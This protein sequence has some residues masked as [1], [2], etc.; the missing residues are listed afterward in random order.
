MGI[1]VKGL[2][3]LK[4]G[5]WLADA[6]RGEGTLRAKGSKN[7]ARFYFRYRDS[8]G[9]YDDLP[10]G[11]FDDKGVNGLDL[12]AARR[13]AGELS[14]RYVQGQRDLRAVL[15][16]EARELE[17]ER[18]AAD[19]AAE[20][21]AQEQKATLGVVLSGY[22]EQLRRDAKPSAAA[23]ERALARHVRLAWP[24]LW[25]KPASETTTDDLLAVVARLANDDKLREAAKLRAYLRAAFAAAIK[26]RRDARAVPALRQAKVKHNPAQDLATIDGAH[27]ARDR[28]LSV[29]ELRAYWRKIEALEGTRGA[30]LRFHLLTGAQRLEQLARLTL[31]DYDA[32]LSAIRL[33][34]AKGRRKQ[35]RVHVVP[36]IPAAEESMRAMLGGELGAFLFTANAGAS[37]AV[38]TTFRSYLS[39]VVDA[40][41]EDDELPG[42][43]FTPGDLRRTVETRLAA[44]GV[45]LDV[46]AQLQ[47]HGLGGLQ[48]RHYDRH[49][50][51]PEKRAALE[52]LHRLVSATPASV[53]PIR[54]RRSK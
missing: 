46:R 37:G 40:M 33:R 53:T 43:R 16:A 36:L 25:D 20:A 44:E 19:A 17:R 32:D 14:R 2:Q 28:A 22:V 50:Y 12:V 18:R 31:E 47:S 1:T 8:Q 39:D 21:R 30:M 27:R 48:A 54:A 35:A 42:G 34:D 41:Q 26:A 45:S 49:D 13:R 5:K 29:A 9:Q 23:V 4:P 11:S 38:Y 24:R 52:T 7:G 51:L 10:L 6:G 3:A 15:D